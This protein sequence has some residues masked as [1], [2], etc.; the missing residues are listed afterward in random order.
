M[1]PR[2]LER[3]GDTEE[4]REGGE[5]LGVCVRERKT[6]QGVSRKKTKGEEE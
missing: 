4:K 1:G 6:G 2:R 5:K 3:E